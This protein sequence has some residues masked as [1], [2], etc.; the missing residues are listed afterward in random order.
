MRAQRFEGIAS[1]SR[2]RP[3]DDNLR[4]FNEMKIYS[5]EVCP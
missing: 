4:I 3:I 2:E 5:E 1:K